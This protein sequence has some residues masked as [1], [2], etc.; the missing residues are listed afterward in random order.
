MP[1]T[2][3]EKETSH[4]LVS[5]SIILNNLSRSQQMSLNHLL[6]CIWSGEAAYG[7]LKTN[8]FFKKKYS[9]A[10]LWCS[11]NKLRKTDDVI[12]HYS[13]FCSNSL[14]ER[15]FWLKNCGGGQVEEMRPQKLG[16]RQYSPAPCSNAQ[17]EIN[18]GLKAVELCIFVKTRRFC[19]FINQWIVCHFN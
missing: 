14:Q 10:L 13:W 17:L 3:Q 12:S 4:I 5:N 18:I 9:D 19:F 1:I 6:D 15:L 16:K 2:T 7:E 11:L 8:W